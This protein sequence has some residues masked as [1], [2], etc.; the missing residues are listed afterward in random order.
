[1]RTLPPARHEQATRSD[2]VDDY[3]GEKV[4]DPYRWLEDT[5]SLET[6]SWIKQQNDVTEAWLGKVASREE[7]RE[8]L[9]QLW[10]FPKFGVPFSRGDRWFQ[11][12]NSGLQNQSVLYLMNR[13]D[14]NGRV[15]LDPNELSDDGTVA[16]EWFAVT[17]DGRHLAYSTSAG[18][19][20]WQTWHVR[21]V[22]SGNDLPDLIE[23]SKFSVATW[24]DD[25]S[26]FYYGQLD[27]PP[28]GGEYLEATSPRRVAFHRLGTPQSDDKVVYSKPEEPEWGPAGQVSDDGRY[29]IVSISHGTRPQ[30]QLHVLDLERP[31]EGL[32][33][34]VS[35]FD[36]KVIYVTNKERTFYLL[37]DYEADR[38]RL[39][40][41]DLDNPARDNWR[42]V[43]GE[44]NALLLGVAFCG[45]KF[46]CHYLEDGCSRLR[47]FEQDGHF[48]HEVDLPPIGS[49]VTE[50]D[51]CGIEG[52]SDA[53]LV[54]FALVSFLDS[55]SIYQHDLETKKT[56]AIWQAD[57][58]LDK[59]GCSS[60]QVFVTAD[61]GVSIPLFLTRRKDLEA[62]GE[63][64]T[65][66]YGYGGFDISMKPSY[67]VTWNA[68]VERGG[69]LAV[70]CLRGG[71]EYGQRWHAAGMR[72]NKQR[73][74]D[75]FADCARY[76]ASSGWTKPER[77]AINGG[78]NGGLLVGASVTQHPE[79]FGAAVA[80]VGVLDM[81]RFHKFTIGWAWKSDYGDPDIEDEYRWLRPYSPL[82]NVVVGRPYPPILITT[83]DHDDRVVPGHSF[84]FAATLQ[85]A[86]SEDPVN[87]PEPILLRVETSGG[88]GHGVPTSKAIARATDMLSFLE[89]TL[90]VS[91]T[92]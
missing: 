9:F 12:R 67:S 79:L 85:Q 55:G 91:A 71:G 39:I 86:Q 22:E 60:E 65:L 20:D 72:E 7:I 66:L 1:M 10:D 62:S 3:H 25:G 68:F 74:F 58:K 52:R 54:H 35:D 30:E 15:L 21:E 42:E 26:G 77:L 69:L 37:T 50:R 41:L 4:P 2:Q 32:Q 14:E 90:G 18:G 83:G 80:D 45:G 48:S 92:S 84:K 70:A 61:D 47:V 36:S 46:A 24:R 81:L 33:A 56:T 19:S 8:R 75:D 40:A 51:D 31:E 53:S 16:V 23:W 73:V 17:K 89:A 87:T 13:P 5:Y 63:V 78:S 88:H 29:L 49:I 64:P 34:V 11:M 59:Q 6:A 76:L 82:H 27:Q 38:Q 28:S 43:I 57:S 44:K